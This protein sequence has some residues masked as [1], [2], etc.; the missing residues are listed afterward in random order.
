MS[1][2]LIAIV[3][4]FLGAGKTTLLLKAAALLHAR[5]LRVAVITNDQ[6]GELVDT[7]MAAA[8]G[9][10]AEE[11]TGGCFCCRFSDFVSA[12]GR[13]LDFRPDV[14]FAEPVGSCTDLSATILQPLKAYERGR[15]ELAPFTVLVD[16]ARAKELLGPAGDPDMAFLFKHQIAEADLLCFTK[17]DRHSEFPSLGRPARRL[18][19]HTGEGIGE[20]LDSVLGGSLPAGGRIVE[21]DYGRYALA[22]AALGWL[23]WHAE[24]GLRRAE[25]PAALV[26]PLLEQVDEALTRAG[27]P[28]A[29]LKVFDRARTGYIKAG[30]C[31]NGEEP[32][33]DGDLLA[34]PARRHD[35]VLNLRARGAP[36][37]LQAMV[38][39]AIGA[40]P[41]TVRVLHR[42]AFRPGAP[43]PEHRFSSV[44]PPAGG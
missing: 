22:E 38:E 25:Q 44:S 37:A 35:L 6:G 41:G 33:V 18:S 16:P 17:A 5:G 26:G 2:T 1:G 23:N 8:S 31:S 19:A 20:W 43:V 36:E 12:A 34:G 29:H 27:I 13:L 7:R 40:V 3:G 15:F 42:Q 28:I 14:I 4:G 30:I 39:Q 9:L 24:I 10:D 32:W 21:V 11:V